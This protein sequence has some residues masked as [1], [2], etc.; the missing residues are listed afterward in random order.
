MVA[1]G[2]SGQQNEHELR[3]GRGALGGA[4]GKAE[5]RGGER[6]GGGPRGEGEEEEETPWSSRDVILFNDNGCE[7]DAC[8]LGNV[9]GPDFYS[10]SPCPLSRRNPRADG[11]PPYLRP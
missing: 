3:A 1:A 4:Q 10:P 11:P 8:Q 5:G 6:K 7:V 2:A 9:F